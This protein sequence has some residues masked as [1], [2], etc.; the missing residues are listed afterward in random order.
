M[1]YKLT[2][3]YNHRINLIWKVFQVR[4][5]LLAQTWQQ[6]KKTPQSKNSLRLITFKTLSSFLLLKLR[7]VSH[8]FKLN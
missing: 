6:Q 7:T 2:T 5:Y 8:I 1:L 3:C 4:I